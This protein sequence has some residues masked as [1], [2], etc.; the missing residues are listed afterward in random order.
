MAFNMASFKKFAMYFILPA[1]LVYGAI[2]VFP[3]ML[4]PYI[5]QVAGQWTGAVCGVVV[6]TAVL[7]VYKKLNI[8]KRME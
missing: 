3:A 4:A 7:W 8:A 5:G 2:Q 1:L 6:I